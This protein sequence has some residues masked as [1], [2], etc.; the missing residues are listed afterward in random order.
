MIDSSAIGFHQAS[1]KV[2]DL[3]VLWI[4]GFRN[5][6]LGFAVEGFGVVSLNISSKKGLRGQIRIVEPVGSVL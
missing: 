2:L 1:S 5:E 4:A 3:T 6:G